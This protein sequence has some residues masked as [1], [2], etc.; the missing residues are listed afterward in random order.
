MKYPAVILILFLGALVLIAGCTGQKAPA[1]PATPVATPPIT[2][3]PLPTSAVPLSTP[4][5]TVPVPAV[6][7][8]TAYTSDEINHHFI[9]LAFSAD[10]D[11][12]RRFSSPVANVAIT[13]A[14]TDSDLAALNRFFLVFNNQSSYTRLPS[15]VK[16]G[17]QGDIVIRFI[18]GNGI[19]GIN[20]DN[21]WKVYRNPSTGII[22]YM[23]RT[24]KYSTLTTEMVYINADMTGKER[25]HWLM[26]GLLYEL[27]LPG[28]SGTYPESLFYSSYNDVTELS[29]IDLKALQLLYG[30]KIKEG[31][32]LDDVRRVL[33]IK[34]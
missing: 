33:V 26:R 5:T 22:T 29:P 12:I 28:E 6:T 25:T 14:Y 24:N 10:N 3:T 31:M 19:E 32:T 4:P 18:P 15:A 7:P 34:T 20:S 11:N 9:D 17:E 23:F 30:N 16:E 27:G 2:F 21:T 1:T 8:R 13:G